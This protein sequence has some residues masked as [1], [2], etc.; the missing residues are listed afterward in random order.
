[1]TTES[2]VDLSDRFYS[3]SFSKFRFTISLYT[4]PDVKTVINKSHKITSKVG[5]K[6]TLYCG[7]EGNPIISH[8]W[9][10][11]KTKIGNSKTITVNLDKKEKFGNYSCVGKN[12]AGEEVILFSLT[13]KRK[14]FLLISFMRVIRPVSAAAVYLRLSRTF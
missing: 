12:N 7:I 3:S 9:Y 10:K 4:S 13:Q 2:F 11:G 1:M 5:E 6:K 8:T 14:A